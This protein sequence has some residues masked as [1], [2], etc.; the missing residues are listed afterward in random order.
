MKLNDIMNTYSVV[1]KVIDDYKDLS[2]KTKFCLLGVLKDLEPTVSNFEQVR[3][4]KITEYGTNNDGEISLTPDNENYDKF[5]KEMEDL[6]KSDVEINI[7]RIKAEDILN[8]PID[9][10]YLVGLYDFIEE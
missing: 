10:K 6:L 9:S 4:D 5:R 8:S 3:N 7:R 2:V 1:S